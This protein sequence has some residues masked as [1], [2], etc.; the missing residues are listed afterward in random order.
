MTSATLREVWWTV[1]FEVKIVKL[2]EKL[3]YNFAGL[4]FILVINQVIY[5]FS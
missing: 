1:T 3:A 4:R 5:K 2:L